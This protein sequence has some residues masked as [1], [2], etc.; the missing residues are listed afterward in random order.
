L[1]VDEIGS[2]PIPATGKE[3]ARLSGGIPA[4]KRKQDL[5]TR[6]CRDLGN[7]GKSVYGFPNREGSAY[8][9]AKRKALEAREIL[10]EVMDNAPVTR[11]LERSRV[12]KT[13]LHGGRYGRHVNPQGKTAGKFEFPK[14]YEIGHAMNR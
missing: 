8:T 6:M 7:R 5:R 1:E 12:E 14:N 10:D 13:R 9:A 2:V 11:P 3:Y 4:L